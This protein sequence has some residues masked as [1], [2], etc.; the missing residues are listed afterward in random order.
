MSR[1]KKVFNVGG[2][3]ANVGEHVRAGVVEIGWAMNVIGEVLNA[4]AGCPAGKFVTRY[5]PVVSSLIITS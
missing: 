4:Q 3:G 1:D 5:C 2:G